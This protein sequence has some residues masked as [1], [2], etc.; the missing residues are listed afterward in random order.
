LRIA[1][2]QLAS[3]PCKIDF[4]SSSPSWHWLYALTLD[5]LRGPGI[6]ILWIARHGNSVKKKENINTPFSAKYTEN[7][8]RRGPLGMEGVAAVAVQKLTQNQSK[9]AIN[10]RRQAQRG[11]T[12]TTAADWRCW[13]RCPALE[14]SE[15][16]SSISNWKTPRQRATLIG[17]VRGMWDVDKDEVLTGPEAPV[18]TALVVVRRCR[19]W[20]LGAWCFLRILVTHKY[21]ER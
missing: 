19:G 17:E 20:W 18:A 1:F 3:S 11:E 12:I 13:Q 16:R 5:C 6:W 10:W 14:M 2:H 7:S 15:N 8:D 4:I 9:N 21:I